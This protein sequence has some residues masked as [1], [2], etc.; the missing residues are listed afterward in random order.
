MLFS[1][2]VRVLILIVINERFFCYFYFL[3]T[4]RDERPSSAPAPEAAGNGSR[5]LLEETL[6]GSKPYP[7]IVLPTVGGFW[8]DGQDQTEYE[9]NTA[10]GGPGSW[11]NKIETD[12]TAKAYRRYY[13]GR[14]SFFIYIY[15]YIFYRRLI[16]VD[17][18]LRVNNTPGERGLICSWIISVCTICTSN[19]LRKRLNLDRKSVIRFFFFF[20]KP[21]A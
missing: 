2:R 11:N 7:N 4:S 1:S 21:N 12:D 15:I 8:V 16:F 6:K 14:V 5:E 9:T 18:F 13:I 20:N 3:Q 19:R 17:F 10:S